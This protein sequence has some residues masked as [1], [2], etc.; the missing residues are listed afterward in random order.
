MIT[1]EKWTTIRAL[2]QKGHSI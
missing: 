2:K 1:I